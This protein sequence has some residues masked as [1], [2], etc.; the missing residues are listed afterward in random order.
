L[1]IARFPPLRF[2]PCSTCLLAYI[3]FSLFE[4][5]CPFCLHTCSPAHL[6]TYLPLLVRVLSSPLRAFVVVHCIPFLPLLISACIL[7]HLLT[8]SPA[9]LLTYLPLLVRVLSSPLRA[10]VVVHCIPFLPFVLA[11]SARILA[12]FFPCLPAHLSLSLC[13]Q[14]KL[15]VLRVFVMVCYL[16]TCS[17][18]AISL[19]AGQAHRAARGAAHVRRRARDRAQQVDPAQYSA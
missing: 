18:I 3:S 5:P 19:F 10:F 13:S 12:Y 6:L 17:P 4:C 8:C 1:F 2:R 7:A 16:L 14:V 9:H 11:L 15:T